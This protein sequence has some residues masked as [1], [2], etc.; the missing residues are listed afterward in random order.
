MNVKKLTKKKWQNRLASEGHAVA[1]SFPLRGLGHRRGKV[2]WRSGNDTVF[3]QAGPTLDS[4]TNWRT[5]NFPLQK[6]KKR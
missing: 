2:R 6:A 4:S 1:G 5:T 3:E